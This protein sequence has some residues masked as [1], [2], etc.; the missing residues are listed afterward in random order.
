V[1]IR[2]VSVRPHSERGGH[3]ALGFGASDD[4][5]T[6]AGSG[7]DLSTAKAYPVPFKSNSGQAGITFG[8][9]GAGNTHQALHLTGRIVQ[10]L[11]SPTG[12]DVL[13]DIKNANVDR[14]ASGVYLYIIEG[15]GQKKKANS[16]SFNKPF[17]SNLLPKQP[18][19]VKN[20]IYL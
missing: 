19:V 1:N 18:S 13:W 4:V 17:L 11:D 12:G 3:G 20:R 14:V 15:A 10:T 6:D 7:S 9:S 16:S 8:E 2:Q 5:V